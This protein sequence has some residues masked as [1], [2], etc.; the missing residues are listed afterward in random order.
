MDWREIGATVAKAAPILGAVVG[1]PVGAIAGAAGALIGSFLG[2]EPTPEA[3]AGALQDPATLVKLKELEAAQQERLLDWQAKQLSAE[4]ENTKDARGMAV[5]LTQAG[6]GMG[7]LAP[8]VVSVIIVLGFFVMLWVMISKVVSTSEATLLML[9]A[10]GSAFGA[11][12]N[13]YLGS[14]LGSL[15]KDAVISKLGGPNDR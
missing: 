11:V 14:S 1:G 9:G 7:T 5:Q 4:L 6:S 12:V 10:L 3:I 8:A 2:V 13:F 15:R